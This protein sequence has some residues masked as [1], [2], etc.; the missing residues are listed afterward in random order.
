MVYQ[1]YVQEK[2]R[3]YVVRQVRNIVILSVELLLINMICGHISDTYLGFLEKML[4]CIILPNGINFFLFCRTKEMKMAYS[5]VE[6]VFR[7]FRKD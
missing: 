4:I 3:Y 1:E 7:R 5:Y 2:I 6:Y